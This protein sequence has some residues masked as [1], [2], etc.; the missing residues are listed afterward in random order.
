MPKSNRRNIK[1]LI[2]EWEKF[3]LIFLQFICSQTEHECFVSMRMRRQEKVE[4]HKLEKLF[5][6]SFETN[7][8]WLNWKWNKTWTS[9]PRQTIIIPLVAFQYNRFRMFCRKWLKEKRKKQ[10][11]IVMN[12]TVLPATLANA[13]YAQSTKRFPLAPTASTV[14][15]PLPPGCT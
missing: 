13:V 11:R 6:K 12:A 2:I 8:G 14:V 4:I 10:F 9:P 3:V 7:F 15:R 1:V 5:E